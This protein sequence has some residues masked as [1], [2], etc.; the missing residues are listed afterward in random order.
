MCTKWLNIIHHPC[1]TIFL[2]YKVSRYLDLRHC[3]CILYT[4]CVDIDQLHRC[5]EPVRHIKGC[6]TNPVSTTSLP[7]WR[8]AYLERVIN[9]H[10][11]LVTQST[12]IFSLSPSLSLSPSFLSSYIPRYHI[13]SLSL[14]LSSSLFLVLCTFCLLWL[15]RPRIREDIASRF[16]HRHDTKRDI[17]CN[18]TPSYRSRS[19]PGTRR[20]PIRPFPRPVARQFAG[21]LPLQKN[22]TRGPHFVPLAL[23]Y[24]LRNGGFCARKRTRAPDIDRPGQTQEMQRKPKFPSY[25]FRYAE[26]VYVILIPQKERL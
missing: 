23:L 11:S 6:V 16:L 17:K 9:I 24:F 15:H 19:G 4:P 8:G 21:S 10:S 1:F 26:N 2:F 18:R 25:C 7:A 13:L 14:L 22:Y 5:I 3:I 12:R 20:K